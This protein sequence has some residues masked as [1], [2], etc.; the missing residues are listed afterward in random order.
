MGRLDVFSRDSGYYSSVHFQKIGWPSQPSPKDSARFS[1]VSPVSSRIFGNYYPWAEGAQAAKIPDSSGSPAPHENSG[2]VKVGPSSLGFERYY[3]QFSLRIPSLFVGILPS[4]TLS[5]LAAPSASASEK[6]L[7][8]VRLIEKK[9]KTTVYNHQTKVDLAKG[10]FEFDCSGMVNWILEQAAPTAYS[11]LKSDRP[12]VAE[13]V[14]ALKKIPFDKPS[15]GW[16]RVQKIADAEPGDVIAWPTPSWYPS[17][18]TG[19]MGVLVAKPEKVSGGYLLRL[20]DA[21][22]YLHGEDTREGGTGFG[23]GTVLISVDPDSG[24][25][26]GQGWTGRYSGNTILKT[27]IYVGRALK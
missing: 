6:I 5:A 25:G 7:E 14:Q 23:Y 9:L 21:T 1:A 18:A 11:E 15:A 13:Y 20:A 12:R 8:I 17:D 22:S 16:R 2:Y 27:P 24:E 3:A 19:H 10:R 4:I 26:S